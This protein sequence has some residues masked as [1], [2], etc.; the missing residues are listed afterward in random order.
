MIRWRAPG[1]VGATILLL[2]LAG[3]AGDGRGGAAAD[4]ATRLLAAAHGGDGATACALLAPDTAAEVGK[5]SG[6]CP[7]GIL[8]ADLPAPGA[9]TGVDVY[10]QWARVTT[11]ADTVFV[12]AFPGGWRVVAAGCRD[13]G[14][15]PYDCA[16]RGS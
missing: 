7:D 12:A 1:A 14:E 16:V 15:R 3:C 5:D 8:A 6:S 4:A 11:A 2:P 10:G 13:R 9:V